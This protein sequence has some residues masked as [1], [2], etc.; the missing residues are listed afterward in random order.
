[1]TG[2]D[3]TSNFAKSNQA[4]WN[5]LRFEVWS[6]HFESAEKEAIR[7]VQN[8]K[9]VLRR[10]LPFIGKVEGSQICS[11]QGSHGR[12]AVAL[13]CLGAT[14]QVIDFSKE[15]YRFALDLAA[16]AGVSID[17]DV[18]DI[19]DAKVPEFK[20]KFD[21]LVL[22][23]GVLHYHWDLDA[24]FSVMRFLVADSGKLF[25]NEFHPVQ[26]KLFW[27]DGPRDYFYSSLVEA[28]VPNP[29]SNGLSLGTCKYRFWNLGEVLTA[30]LNNHF[31]ITHLEEHPDWNDPTIPGS[32]T[33]VADAQ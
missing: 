2:N 31:S 7:L 15:N 14:V 18:R 12:V 6:S 33:L 1:M 8:P 10:I 5:N 30:A 19:I 22:E 17:Y 9:H 25:L 20:G 11:V 32:Y 21:V 26:R 13:A 23:L 29:A 16:A 4:A 27:K 3:S 28:D 24:F